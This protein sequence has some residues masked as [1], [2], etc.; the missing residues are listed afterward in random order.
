ME[1]A[2]RNLGLHDPSW[3]FEP[4]ILFHRDRLGEFV[5]S[6]NLGP[7][8]RWNAAVRGAFYLA[9]VLFFLGVSGVMALSLVVLVVVAN[10][11]VAYENEAEQEEADAALD[12]TREGYVSSNV[13]GDYDDAAA[14]APPT[15]RLRRLG[16]RRRRSGAALPVYD[17][18]ACTPPTDTNP[19]MNVLL[20]EYRT[21]PTRH[22][23]C[24][25]RDN[26]EIK[27][28]VERRFAANSVYHDVGDIY[29]RSQS[30]REYYTAANT[31]IPN[32]Q[33]ELATWLYG[34]AAGRKR[35]VHAH[36]D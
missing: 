20:G 34:E 26:R 35:K 5:P 17:G 32:K 4:T 16:R 33:H 29:N 8:R 3:L 6:A 24:A 18:F 30:Q 36:D 1:T 19:F 9:V 11:A 2:D 15:P 13:V 22:R 10:W 28:D 7:E 25:F 21:N 27:D 23:A 31:T 14:R 12:T